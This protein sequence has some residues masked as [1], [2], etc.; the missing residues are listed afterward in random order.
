MQKF[1][2]TSDIGDAA[3]QDDGAS[4]VSANF[5]SFDSSDFT[6]IYFKQPL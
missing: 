5:L 4:T 3:A 2:A 6:F 1:L